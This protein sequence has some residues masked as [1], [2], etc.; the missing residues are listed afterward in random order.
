MKKHATELEILES[1]KVRVKRTGIDLVKRLDVLQAYWKSKAMM[2]SMK[3]AV[4]LSSYEPYIIPHKSNPKLCFCRLTKTVLNVDAEEL[5][6][7]IKGKKF[8]QLRA[9][10]EARRA[11]RAELQRVR[12]QKEL[13]QSENADFFSANAP[14]FIAG[15][16]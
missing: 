3:D 9:A 14:P 5:S 12:E 11:R 16:I 7:H 4:D 13:R 6:K 8:T 2:N 15:L 1:G 10:T